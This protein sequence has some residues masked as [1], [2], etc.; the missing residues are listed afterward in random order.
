LYE[1]PIG[2]AQKIGQEAN[3]QDRAKPDASASAYEVDW[4]LAQAMTSYA[5][6]QR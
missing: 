6:G 3:H 2:K 5:F 1:A 4:Q